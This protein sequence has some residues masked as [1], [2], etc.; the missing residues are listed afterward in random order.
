[1]EKATSIP[2]C[3]WASEYTSCKKRTVCV[4][5]VSQATAKVTQ[6]RGSK[7]EGPLPDL[8]TVSSYLISQNGSGSSAL[9][10]TSCGGWVCQTNF[11]AAMFLL[12]PLL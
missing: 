3:T 7:V 1:M 6:G 9:R 4:I 5:I 12:Y 2:D 10:H 8:A 11:A